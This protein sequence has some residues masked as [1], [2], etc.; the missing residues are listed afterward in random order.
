M[1]KKEWWG[2]DSMGCRSRPRHGGMHRFGHKSELR[3]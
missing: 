1:R 2:G 3:A